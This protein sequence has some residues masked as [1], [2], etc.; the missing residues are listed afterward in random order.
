MKLSQVKFSQV[1]FPLI[2]IYVVYC[3]ILIGLYFGRIRGFGVSSPLSTKNKSEKQE[4]TAEENILFFFVC[5]VL[6][7]DL[8]FRTFNVY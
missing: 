8:T 4:L 6:V 2:G 3:L 7:T 1:K 5:S